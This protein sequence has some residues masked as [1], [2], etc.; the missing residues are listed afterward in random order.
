MA[1]CK[2]VGCPTHPRDA[3]RKYCSKH[4]NQHHVYAWRDADGPTIGVCKSKAKI[5]GV[6]RKGRGYCGMPTIPGRE[7]CPYHARRFALRRRKK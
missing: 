5:K 3:R 4:R 2:H 1:K 7:K 6:P